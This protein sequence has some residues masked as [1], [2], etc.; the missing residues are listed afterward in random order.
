M[1]DEEKIQEVKNEDTNTNP[2]EPAFL[3]CKE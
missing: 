2:T 1:K 3:S